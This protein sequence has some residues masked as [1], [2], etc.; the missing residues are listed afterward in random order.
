MDVPFRDDADICQFVEQFEQCRWPY[1]QW[2]HR[3]HL[4]IAVYYLRRF[5]FSEAIARLRQSIQR[6]NKACGDPDGY[7]ET[8][9]ILFMRAVD[10]HI[11]TRGGNPSMAQIVEQLA[12]VYTM[13]W[14]LN[15]YSGERL[16][17]AEARRGWLDPDLKPLDF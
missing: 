13:Q 15:F 5:P 17:S 16:W 10:A 12:P 7:H 6:Y 3:A 4:A 9:T 8:I 14:P 11:Q 2:T 1:A